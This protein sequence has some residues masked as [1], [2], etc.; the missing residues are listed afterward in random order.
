MSGTGN[1]YDDAMVQ[2]V[3]RTIKSELIWST[4]YK[5]CSQALP[6]IETYIDGFYNPR[7][8]HTA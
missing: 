4:I 3:F 6:A 2:T 7:R 5:T 8:M 1:C